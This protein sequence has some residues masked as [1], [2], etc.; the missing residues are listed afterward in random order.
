MIMKWFIIAVLFMTT[1]LFAE[2]SNQYRTPHCYPDVENLPIYRIIVGDLHS[3]VVLV[4][5]NTWVTSA[6]SIDYGKTKKITI[7]LPGNKKIR[8]K[9]TWFDDNKDVAVLDANSNNIRPIDRMTFDLIKYE[10]I[11]NIGY[12]AVAGGKILSFTGFQIRYNENNILVT[13]AL[14]LHGMSGGANVRCVDDKLELVGIIT[15]LVKHQTKMKIWTDE[16]GILHSDR[17]LTNKGITLISPIRFQKRD[18]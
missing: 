11:W 18:S 16:K 9:I 8:A 7:Y 17:T 15:S 10:Q 14:G 4:G 6:H 1:T 2:P 12:P 5:K 3:T 13:S